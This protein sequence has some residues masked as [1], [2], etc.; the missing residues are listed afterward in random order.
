M[1]SNEHPG[2]SGNPAD[3]PFCCDHCGAEFH[4][5]DAFGVAVNDELMFCSG[6]CVESW[7]ESQ[8]PEEEFPNDN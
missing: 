4:E 5:E 7:E 6:D 8:R 1:A 2:M 3:A